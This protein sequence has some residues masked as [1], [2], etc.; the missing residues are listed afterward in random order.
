MKTLFIVLLAVSFLTAVFMIR[1]VRREQFLI[2]D[3][4]YW[5]FF[6]LVLI[7]LS[8][9]P[10]VSVF[11]ADLLGF[12]EPQ[13]FVFVAIIF[14]LL[15][16]IFLLS[17]KTSVLESKLNELIETYAIDRQETDGDKKETDGSNTP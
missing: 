13:N 7:V 11:F 16:K 6:C 1:K 3:T 8:V 9:F 2:Q 15:I 12:Q 17:V 10:G 4:L 5:I 14:L